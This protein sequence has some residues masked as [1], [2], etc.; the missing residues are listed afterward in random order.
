MNYELLSNLSLDNLQEA[1]QCL[2]RQE[3]PQ[4]PQVK[5]LGHPE[6]E[7]I[8]QL[9]LGLLKEKNQSALH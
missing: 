2:Y 6:W 5:S 1:M 3:L 4:S 7:A 9:L 8:S